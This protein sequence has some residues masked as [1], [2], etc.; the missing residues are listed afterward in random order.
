MPSGGYGRVTIPAASVMDQFYG[1]C[2]FPRPTKP[3]TKFVKVHRAAGHERTDG[4]LDCA[5][6]LKTTERDVS[7][8]YIYSIVA[9]FS[10][11]P[12]WNTFATELNV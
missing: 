2:Q 1:R 9:H 11:R 6:I 10:F 12:E 8:D 5:P 7:C 4:T 3:A